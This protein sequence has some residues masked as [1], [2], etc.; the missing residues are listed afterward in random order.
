MRNKDTRFG[1]KNFALTSNDGYSYHVIPHSEAKGLAGKPGKDLTSKVVFDFSTK[2]V[3]I[4][5]KT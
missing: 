2:L 1:Y 5:A 4:K 3:G